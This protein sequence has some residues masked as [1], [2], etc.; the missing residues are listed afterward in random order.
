MTGQLGK[1]KE[2]TV[3]F[4]AGVGR[5]GSTLLDV[6]LNALDGMATVGELCY[7]WE[8]GY[9]QNL[10]CGCGRPFSE[11]ARWR[12]IRSGAFAGEMEDLDAIE[13]DR[14]TVSRW[15]HLPKLF[16]PA[17]R[18]VGFRS[19]LRRYG[20]CLRRILAAAAEENGATVVVDSSKDPLHGLILA[21]T[22]GID[23][24]VVHLVRDPRATTFSRRRLK[25]RPEVADGVSYM[26]RQSTL[27][28]ALEW[29]FLNRLSE[30]VAN[31]AR[32]S[33]RLRYDDFVAAPRD[34]LTGL[35]HDLG[36]PS[37][38]DHFLEDGRALLGVNHTVAGNPVRFQSGEIAINPDD[39]WQEEMAPADRRLVELVTGR[40]AASYGF[41]P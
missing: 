35:C 36:L 31:A 7:I 4:V 3:L 28:S 6:C 23:L 26:P 39:E 13:R 14:R 27:V 1:K 17:L 11:C 30:R 24:R 22:P 10:L 18:S 40:L 15:R 32:Q 37:S 41:A 29:V 34:A 25:R 2:Q 19:S 21:Q 38:S 20:N 12:A 16:F 33:V 8:N 9:R 5:S